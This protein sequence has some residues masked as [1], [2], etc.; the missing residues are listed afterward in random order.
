MQGYVKEEED[1]NKREGL[2]ES[3]TGTILHIIFALIRNGFIFWAKISVQIIYKTVQRYKN[4]KEAFMIRYRNCIRGKGDKKRER[5]RENKT[6]TVLLIFF[7]NK[8]WLYF[9]SSDFCTIKT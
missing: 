3:K 6:G 2:R 7:A 9:L 4:C 5:L 8:K 1:L